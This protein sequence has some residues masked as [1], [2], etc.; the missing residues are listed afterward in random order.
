MARVFNKENFQKVTNQMQK[1]AREQG[2]NCSIKRTK[3]IIIEVTGRHDIGVINKFVKGLLLEDCIKRVGNRYEVVDP[4][5]TR[6]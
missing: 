3:Q 1:E 5:E 2:E 6:R 4:E